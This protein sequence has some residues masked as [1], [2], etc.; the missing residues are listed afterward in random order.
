MLQRDMFPGVEEPLSKLRLEEPV[1]LGV[2]NGGSGKL[3]VA[4]K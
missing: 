4:C 3:W 2:P 1:E